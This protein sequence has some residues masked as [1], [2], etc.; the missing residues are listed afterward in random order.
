MVPL[1]KWLQIFKSS[2]KN[3]IGSYNWLQSKAELLS[4][5]VSDKFRSSYNAIL[6][7]YYFPENVIQEMREKAV[8][9]INNSDFDLIKCVQLFNK[10]IK[11]KA[12]IECYENYI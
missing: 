1:A 3:E 6:G 9:N 7:E 4:E 11:G 2:N 10:W 8:N 12:L 5:D